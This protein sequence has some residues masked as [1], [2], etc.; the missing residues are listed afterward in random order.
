[1]NTV[2]QILI[3]APHMQITAAARA[4]GF[5]GVRIESGGVLLDG[6][7]AS[8][9]QVEQLAKIVSAGD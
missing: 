4:L 1:M 3:H 5:D 8:R 2:P 6:K 9:E 7:P